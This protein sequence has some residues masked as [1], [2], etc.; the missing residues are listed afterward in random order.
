M[1]ILKLAA[2][3][4]PQTRFFNLRATPTIAAGL[5]LGVP[6]VTSCHGAQTA[7]P[8]AGSLSIQL[9]VSS[10]RDGRIPSSFTCD[11]ANA[12]PAITWSAAPAATKS[13]ALVVADPDAP[14]GTF[15]HWVLFNL[16]AAARSL[17]DAVP[18]MD[19]LPDGSRQGRNDFGNIGYGGPC[20]P[21]HS[22]HRYVFDLY[23]VDT[24]LSLPAGATRQQV[25]DALKGHIL[26]R[27]ELIGR[28]NR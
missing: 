7:V 25:E 3:A 23:A 18:A 5:L 8:G 20:P 1:R 10:F 24:I 6:G 11:G 26:A 15:V 2:M 13:F 9:T 21:G 27:G 22:S 17:P 14:M 19:Q 28:Y 16:P 12:S 4:F